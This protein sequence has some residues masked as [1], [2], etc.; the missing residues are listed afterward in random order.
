MVLRDLGGVSTIPR[1]LVL[2]GNVPLLGQERANIEALHTLQEL[3]CKVRFLIRAEYTRDTIQAELIRRGIEFDT[4]PYFD[5]VQYRQPLRVWLNNIVGVLGGSWR[6][7]QQV[8]QYR[9]THIHAGSTSNVLN[10][11]LALMVTRLPLV[12]RAGDVPPQHHAL[13]RWVWRFTRRRA[14]HFVCDSRFIQTKLLELGVSAYKTSVVYAPA[15][16]RTMASRHEPDPRATNAPFTVLYLGQITEEKGVHLLVDAALELCRVRADIWFT[17]AGAYDW[18]N[19]FAEALM[20]RVRAAGMSERISFVG[21]VEDVDALF[22]RAQLHVCPSLCEEAYGLTVVEAKVRKVPSLVFPSGGLRELI[23]QGVDGTVCEEKSADDLRRAI[24]TY[25]D[26]PDLAARHG[27]A[28]RASLDRLNVGQFGKT[29]WAIYQGVAVHHPSPINSVRDGDV[30]RGVQSMRIDVPASNDLHGIRVLAALSG[31]E[32][33][34]HERG[35]IEVFKALRSRGAEVIVGVTAVENGGAVGAYVRELGFETFQIPFGNQWSRQWLKRYPLSLFEK[36]QQVAVCSYVFRKTIQRF[37][38]THIHIGSPLVY[39]YLAIALMT[40]RTPL[41]YRMGDAPPTD[42]PFNLRIW[43]MA[44]RRKTCLVAV[45][46][47]VRQMALQEGAPDAAVIYNLAPSSDVDLE[48]DLEPV[49]QLGAIRLVYV[50]AIAEHKG[51]VPLVQ[52]L[53]RI[54]PDHPGLHL[55][56]VGGSQYDTAFREHLQALIK[57]SRINSRVTFHGQVSWPAPFYLRAA[58]H[59]APSVWE[60]PLGN[61][62]MEAKREGTPSVVFP[63][64]GLVEMIRHEVDGFICTEKSTDSLVEALRWML[65]DSDRLQRM[66]EAA[67]ADFAA[68]FGPARFAREWADV[69]RAARGSRP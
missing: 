55:D 68:R 24:E 31:L 2:F 45:S 4:V 18:R 9:A 43:R 59:V 66:G 51:L 56:V 6:L 63:S 38:P 64:G 53:A 46:K 48:Q 20:C 39:S 10:F 67:R 37:D 12:F 65:A 54:A 11:I 33:F 58:I 26:H 29:W 7:L 36:M 42:S 44:M 47:Y 27:L 40:C 8:R 30:G 16:R 69:Y 23:V 32:L 41:V 35:N 14:A 15:P 62:V 50:G 25:A 60:E 22:G 21:F 3:G 52:A 49:D 34:G 19:H 1:I 61:V 5:T 17:I 13:W 57:A 28:A